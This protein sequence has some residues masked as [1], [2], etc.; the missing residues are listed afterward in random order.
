MP[1]VVV[2]IGSDEDSRPAVRWAAAEAARR[3]VELVAVHVVSEQPR[4][5]LAR[6]SSSRSGGVDAA[7]S[8]TRTARRLLSKVVELVGTEFPSVAVRTQLVAG[9][10]APV[11][12]ALSERAGLV[13]IGGKRQALGRAGH[14]AG[15]LGG[16]GRAPLVVVHSDDAIT[17]GPVV[18]GIDMGPEARHALDVAF[19]QA[20]RMNVALHV[21]HAIQRPIAD[22]STGMLA[23]PID[24]STDEIKLT[25]SLVDGWRRQY[26]RVE[27]VES[28]HE[29]GAAQA[30]IDAAQGASMIVVGSHGRSTLAALLLGS[31]SRTLVGRAPCPVAVVP[32]P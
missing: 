24:Q 19:D 22:A 23:P 20:S 9:D 27:V 11:L 6:A 2:G 30:L 8:E 26:P 13:V 14:L 4:W 17:S 28:T 16:H 1:P 7:T 3:S 21:V 25:H 5:S 31:V 18:V 10:V 32:S 15:V 12:G 29:G